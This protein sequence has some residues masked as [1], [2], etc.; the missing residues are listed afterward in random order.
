MVEPGA[1]VL[2]PTV[3]RPVREADSRR[4]AGP[5]LADASDMATTILPQLRYVP[6]TESGGVR[7][8]DVGGPRPPPT[9]APAPTSGP[10]GEDLQARA[11]WAIMTY[12]GKVND[13]GRDIEADYIGSMARVGD[14]EGLRVTVLARDEQGVAQLRRRLE[15]RLPDSLLNRMEILPQPGYEWA[16]D[17]LH[18]RADGSL[19]ASPPIDPA[20][21][22][23]AQMQGR[24][25]RVEPDGPARSQNEIVQAHPELGFNANGAAGVDRQTGLEIAQGLG[26]PAR[27][28]RTYFEG[29]NVLTGTD[30]E[31]RPYALVGR[32]TIA[33][34]R[35]VLGISDDQ[36]VHR[37]IANDLGLPPERVHAVEQPGEFHLDMA[38]APWG[39]GT[40]LLNDSRRAMSVQE[41]TQRLSEGE[42]AALRRASELRGTMEDRAEREL[43]A[44]GFDVV[45]VPGRFFEARDGQVVESANFL[46]GEGG[47]SPDGRRFFA[48][49]RASNRRTERAFLDALPSDPAVRV[50]FAVDP[51]SAAR[52]L[53]DG[54][55][56]NCRVRRLP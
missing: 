30:R 33:H 46:N 41:Q 12:S 4:I 25:R 17:A 51:E 1:V 10:V 8:A 43:R 9:S 42:R 6:L 49:Q 34:N 5:R 18:A 24:Y 35:A 36:E 39:P 50:Y 56:L 15:Q 11:D 40:V 44:Q 28:G 13:N 27:A 53:R 47:T 52:S 38:I 29:G 22:V 54:G 21:G 48:T 45:R 37:Q 7:A 14:R 31:G 32:D 3:D 23:E 20:A 19:V 16:E 26:L 2:A 55:S